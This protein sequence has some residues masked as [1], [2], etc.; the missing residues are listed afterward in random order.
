MPGRPSRVPE[1]P[2]AR[3]SE[4]RAN[5]CQR[6]ERITGDFCVSCAA[7]KVR[8]WM[9]MSLPRRLVCAASVL[10]WFGVVSLVA[11]GGTVLEPSGHS[12]GGGGS[13][14]AGG[15]GGVGGSGGSG[16]SGG[17][18]GSG[19]SGGS[20]GAGGSGI[21]EAGSGDAGVC[22]TFAATASDLTCNIDSDCTV[23][24]AGTICFSGGDVCPCE[25]GTFATA[26]NQTGFS[27]YE[28]AISS[29]PQ[30]DGG[31]VCS[32]PVSDIICHKHQ[33]ILCPFET[34]GMKPPPGCPVTLPP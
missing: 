23:A 24:Y 31:I 6:T 34:S 8:K 11:C 15:S 33:C 26:V 7:Q 14:A 12:G 2:L 20:G 16:A 9:A 29:L 27:A 1:I 10:A 17:S 13:G 25:E 4:D 5:L 28:S 21:G 19:A 18:G 32:C 3:P 22:V 30:G